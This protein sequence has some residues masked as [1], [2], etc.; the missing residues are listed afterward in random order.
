MT[1]MYQPFYHRYFTVMSTP[2]NR[3]SRV[4]LTARGCSDKSDLIGWSP[5]FGIFSRD[6]ASGNYGYPAPSV[7]FIVQAKTKTKKK[8]KKKTVT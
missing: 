6:A 7:K 8:Y 5:S 1:V 2:N 3:P 4:H